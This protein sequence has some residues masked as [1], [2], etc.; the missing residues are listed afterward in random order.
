VVTPRITVPVK[1]FREATVI[2]ERPGLPVVPLML[3]GL[4]VKPKSG[5]ATTLIVKVITYR[6]ACAS[7]Y[8]RT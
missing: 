5:L 3:V 1:P 4:A 6:A 8:R 2:V 7:K